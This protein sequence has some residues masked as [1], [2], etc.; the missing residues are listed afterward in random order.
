VSSNKALLHAKQYGIGRA[1]T[2][3]VPIAAAVLPDSWVYF[4]R[5]YEEFYVKQNSR[6]KILAKRGQYA[7]QSID[8]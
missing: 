7:P 1:L 5:P 4:F 2:L 8:Y 3:V 6:N